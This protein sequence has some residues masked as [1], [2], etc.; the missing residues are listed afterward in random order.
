LAKQKMGC[1]KLVEK[2]AN[3]LKNEDVKEE[4]QL[5]VEA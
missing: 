1:G 5:L 2:R 4:E 3:D